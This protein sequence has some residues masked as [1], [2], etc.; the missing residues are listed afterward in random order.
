MAEPKQIFDEMVMAG[1][2]GVQRIMEIENLEDSLTPADCQKV[3]SEIA[4]F[5][6][7]WVE[8]MKVA[9]KGQSNEQK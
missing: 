8:Y 9:T 5:M 4:K 7:N 3:G 1:C 6:V 2:K